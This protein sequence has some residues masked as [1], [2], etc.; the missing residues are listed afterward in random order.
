MIEMPIFEDED[1]YLQN[2]KSLLV[3]GRLRNIQKRAN[4]YNK[5]WQEINVLLADIICDEDF[6]NENSQYTLFEKIILAPYEDLKKIHDKIDERAEDIFLDQVEDNSGKVKK[7]I[8]SK[9]RSI[10]SLYDKFISKGLN[11]QLVQKYG[12]KCC[13][14]C[15]ENY[16]INRKKKNNQSYAMAQLDHFYPRDRFPIFA[17]SL[18]NLIPSCST[19]NHIKSIK[20]IGVSPHDHTRNFSHLRIT[21]M[22]KSSGWIDNAEEIEL[23][24]DY[25]KYDHDFQ[26]GMECNLE[27]MGIKSSYCTHRDYV[28]E[29]LKKAQIYGK[30]MR[31]NLLN[32][33]PELFNSDDELIR[34]I[35]SNYID[36][37][38]A[39]KRPLSKLTQDLLKELNII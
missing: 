10:Y 11:T 32:D 28:Q 18:Y 22:P 33:F 29:L 7:V 5:K 19:C 25:D 1:W 15:N 34:I 38:D 30:E 9:W 17:I 2:V 13:P 37:K 24:F 20:E 36:E 31:S 16:I 6:S 26:E 14:Y 3:D 21:Y 23:S 8:K 12:I 39:L 35:F 4:D 27:T